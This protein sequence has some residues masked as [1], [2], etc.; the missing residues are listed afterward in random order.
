MIIPW[1]WVAAALMVV[2]ALTH[3]VLGEKR[4]IGPILKSQDGPLAV[5]L[6][7]QVL[8]FAW[9]FTTILMILCAIT[10]AYPQTPHV[11]NGVI[12]AGWLAAGLFDLAVTRGKHVGW[13]MLTAAGTCA[14]Y[15]ALA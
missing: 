4:L 6:G 1:Y 12:G 3:S 8:R 7:R 9:H 5:P 14:L 10:V 13:P 11:I 15:G 2:T